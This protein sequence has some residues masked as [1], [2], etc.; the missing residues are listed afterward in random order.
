[1]EDEI[2]ISTKITQSRITNN[3]NNRNEISLENIPVIQNPNNEENEEN[4][5]LIRHFKITNNR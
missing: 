2:S 4:Q 3:I 1:M 5:E